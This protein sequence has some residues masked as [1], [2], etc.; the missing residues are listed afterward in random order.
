MD[1][2]V[3][4]ERVIMKT[5]VKIDEDSDLFDV[6]DTINLTEQPTNQRTEA[7]ELDFD[8]ESFEL[9]S[10]MVQEYEDEEMF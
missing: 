10:E 6:V 3:F 9:Y 7:K 8:K 1:S 4:T 5:E 2:N